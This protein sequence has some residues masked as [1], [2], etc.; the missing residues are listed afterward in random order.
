MQQKLDVYAFGLLLW[1]LQTQ[2]QPWRELDSV[3]DI[4][5]AVSAPCFRPMRP[6]PYS[7]FDWLR[8]RPLP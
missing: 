4:R 1:V 8:C 5:A 3:T 2:T 7:V 6:A